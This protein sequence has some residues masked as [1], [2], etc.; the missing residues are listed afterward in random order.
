MVQIMMSLIPQSSQRHI[1]RVCD[2][3]FRASSLLD[4]HMRVHVGAKPYVC[5]TCGHRAT[6]KGN[7]KL[8]MKK[9]HGTDLPAHIDMVPDSGIWR[10]NE[11]VAMTELHSPLSCDSLADDPKKKKV[12]TQAMSS[13]LDPYVVELIKRCQNS[14]GQGMTGRITE[15]LQDFIKVAQDSNFVKEND[16]IQFNNNHMDAPKSQQS[17]RATPTHPVENCASETIPHSRKPEDNKNELASSFLSGMPTDL[18]LLS[19]YNERLN[20]LTLRTSLA[21][22]EEY[23]AYLKLYRYNALLEQRLRHKALRPVNSNEE[24]SEFPAQ[25]HE[26]LGNADEKRPDGKSDSPARVSPGVL[27]MLRKTILNSVGQKASNVEKSRVKSN[28]ED[29]GDEQAKEVIFNLLPF[30]VMQAMKTC[31]DF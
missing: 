23:L 18:E 1:C 8:H 22:K 29:K 31:F 13:L 30:P 9:H 2:K 19:F 21:D 5:P 16:C 10:D 25:F 14:V 24:C 27:R 7:L 15:S 17:T 20:N 4:I 28:D 6:Q 3:T 12:F 26:N 11:E